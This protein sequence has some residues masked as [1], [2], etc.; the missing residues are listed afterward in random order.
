MRKNL[1]LVCSN[2]Q[3]ET[4]NLGFDTQ[5]SRTGG[6]TGTQE[7]A[8]ATSKSASEWFG[9]V[10]KNIFTF[11]QRKFATLR[12]QTTR[13]RVLMLRLLMP[14]LAFVR[15]YARQSWCARIC[16]WFVLTSNRKPKTLVLIRKRVVLGE[17]LEPKKLLAQHQNSR[18]GL[19]LSTQPGA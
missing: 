11:C 13:S 8:S 16:D 10:L 7:T 3:P 9:C 14:E 19:V 5:T 4:K 18:V 6:E 2:V 15:Q 1:R 17:K 12:R